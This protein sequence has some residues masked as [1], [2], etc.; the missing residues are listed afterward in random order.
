MS[1]ETPFCKDHNFFY[2]HRD[3]VRKRGERKSTLGSNKVDD[4]VRLSDG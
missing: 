2:K 3:T 1:K 4:N